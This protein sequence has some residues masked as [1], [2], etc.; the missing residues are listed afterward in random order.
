MVDFT[1]LFEADQDQ[2]LKNYIARLPVYAVD[3]ETGFTNY[4]NPA[5]PELKLPVQGVHEYNPSY[6]VNEIERIENER[7]PKVF[8]PVVRQGISNVKDIYQHG[9]DTPENISAKVFGPMAGG[10]SDVQERT[11]L[12]PEKMIR[13][14]VSLP[15]DVMEGRVLTGPG[16]RPTDFSDVPG[17]PHPLANLIERTQDMAGLAAGGSVTSAGLAA[18]K[19]GLLARGAS[20][21]KAKLAEV[22]AEDAE[23]GTG[24]SAARNSLANRLNEHLNE[25]Q[26]R[27]NE[28]MPEILA[29]QRASEGYEAAIRDPETKKLYTGMWHEEVLDKIAKDKGVPKEY[30]PDNLV[31]GYIND[32]G[33]FLTEEAVEKLSQAKSKSKTAMFRSDDVVGTGLAAAAAPRFYSH[34]ENLINDAKTVTR[35][36]EGKRVEIPQQ[37]FNG[38]ELIN[39]L[40]NKG[41]TVEEMEALKIPEFLEGKKSVTRDELIKHLNE[42]KVELEEKVLGGK[43]TPENKNKFIELEAKAREIE[44]SGGDA[45]L[46]RQQLDN[47]KS[48][49]PRFA[50]YQLPGGSNYRETLLSLKDN[51]TKLKRVEEINN[52]I[53]H[54]NQRLRGPKLA[55]KSLYDEPEIEKLTNRKYDLAAERMDLEQAFTHEHWPNNKNVVVHSRM[56]DR[57]I[58]D[59]NGP[60]IAKP[61]K[62]SEIYNELTGKNPKEIK[63]LNTLHAEEIQS[64]LHQKGN[65]EGYKL[66][67]KD[68]AKLEPEFNRIEEKIM[69]HAE[70]TGDESIVSN[71]EIK[72]AV[73]LAIDK[74]VI[75]EAEA[76]TYLRYADSERYGAVKDAPFKSNWSDLMVKRL[77][78]QAAEEGKDAIS[79]TPGQA[80]ADRYNLRKHIKE[81]Q[82][83]KHNDGTYELGITDKNGEGVPTPEKHYTKETLKS[84]VGK[85]I[86]DK[87]IAGEG[88]SYR[89]RNSKTLDDVDLEMGGEFHKK[90]YD[91]ILVNKVNAIAKKY[92]GRV[93]EKEIPITKKK[94]YI[95]GEMIMDDLGIPRNEQRAYWENL[96]QNERNRLF[97]KFEKQEAKQKIWVLKLTPELKKAALEKGFSMFETGVPLP[98]NDEQK[99]YRLVPVSHNPFSQRL[100]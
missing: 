67:Q 15:V 100:M 96:P 45:T 79:W 98:A 68:K 14:G 26:Y 33:R 64:D 3:P 78:R 72:D 41:A 40:K 94:D 57:F 4:S 22:L 9:F 58:P 59:E 13:S 30:L 93:E 29:R 35:N 49:K 17:A 90:F 11:Q 38:T 44:N 60:S 84:V 69:K 7:N 54:I 21:L 65:S 46:I 27:G 10:G 62:T 8:M 19:P 18:E 86:A 39:Y 99:K 5:I 52:E 95:S 53:A 76:K 77:I 56:N 92:G 97:D 16:L 80:Q 55:N 1:K 32:R 42:N 71:P 50:Q 43:F 91:E 61:N 31:K 75:T 51:P 82:Y 37:K 2:A 25:G 63:G 81:I 24:I 70:S 34:V 36:A 6:T 88:K 87:I 20:S 48:P 28:T 74:K 83:I 47:L 12:W 73:K 89:G 23:V 66:S 85:E